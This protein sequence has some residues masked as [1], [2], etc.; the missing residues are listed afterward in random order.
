MR[1]SGPRPP[2]HTPLP[3]LSDAELERN[4][5]FLGRMAGPTVFYSPPFEALRRLPLSVCAGELSHGQMARRTALA[6]ADTLAV[7]LIEAPGN[8]LGPSLEPARFAGTLKK[9]LK[10]NKGR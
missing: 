2:A 8:H 4:R 6:L 10:A 9:L 1:A 3:E 7:P 5:Y